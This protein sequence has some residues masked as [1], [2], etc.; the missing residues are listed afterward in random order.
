MKKIFNTLLIIVL[1][2]P[3]SV[4]AQQ[5]P[6]SGFESFESD[7]LNGTGYRPVGWNA[8]NVKRTVVGITATGDL[9]HEYASGRN[10]KCVRI[11]NEAVGAAGIK[12]NAPA[13][14]SLGKPWNF[15]SGV[16]T[17]SATAGTDGGVAF[18]YRPDSLSVWVRRTYSS[19]ED[20]NIV[21]YLWKG[22]SRGDSYR[23]KDGGCSGT[24]HY[25][26]ESDIR[27]AYDGNDCGTAVVATQIGEGS[28]RSNA[29]ITSWT[30]VKVPIRY[31]TND[32]PEKMNVILSAGN[33]P[34]KRQSTGVYVGSTLFCD[35]IKFIYSSRADQILLNNRPMNGFDRDKLKYSVEL[36]DAAT[37]IPEIT[38]KRSGRNLAPSE[39]TIV[40]GGVGGTT[41]ITIRAED[42]KSSTTYSI[43]F[44]TKLS[45]NPRPDMISVGGVDIPNFIP[46]LYEYDVE[47]PFGTTKCPEI[48]VDI[49]EGGQT[50]TVTKPSSL[51]GTAVVNVV[52][53][54]VAYSQEY[55]INM[56]VGALTDNTLTGI[57]VDGEM[58]DNFLPTTNNYRLDLPLGTTSTPEITYTTA[59]P[60]DHNVVVED[61]GI[62]G[63]V[64]ISVTPKGTSLTRVYRITFRITESSNAKLSALLVDGD[65]IDGFSADVLSYNY[66]LPL[67]TSALPSVTWV[68]GDDYQNVELQLG[69]LDGETRIIVTAQSGDVRVYKINFKTVK[70][71]V[72][73]LKNIY[74]DS[75]AID[76]FDASIFEYE[77]KLPIGTT[78]V[79]EVTWEEGDGYQTV[80]LYK[81][82]LSGT[83]RVVVKAQNG[84][85]KTYSI[86]F[87]VMKADNS[88]LKDIL[89]GGVSVPNFHS[90]TLIYNIDLP[91]GTS[92]LPEITYVA[93]DA[94]QVIRKVEGGVDGVT[95]IT[96]KAQ[97]GAMTVYE[98]RFSVYKSSNSHLADIIVDGKTIEGFAADK[99]EYFD[100]LPSGTIDL[101]TIE[102]VKGDSYQ[103]VIAA[104]EG[105][106][107]KSTITVTAEDGTQSVYVIHF[108]VEKSVSA[109]LK[110]IFVD[111][112]K[113]PNFS[114]DVMSY[115]MT[116]EE[117]ATECP[118]VTVDKDGSQSVTITKPMFEGTVKIE[119]QPEVGSKNV[120]TI[121]FKKKES[122]DVHLADITLGGFSIPNYVPTES[123]Y[124]LTVPRGTAVVPVV[125]YTRNDKRQSVY[126]EKGG[127]NE[128]TTIHV[129][130]E[131]GETFAYRLLIREEENAESTL[132]D[133]KIGGVSLAGFRADSLDYEYELPLTQVEIPSVE[134]VKSDEGQSIMYV[135]PQG[136]GVATI[137]VIA[138]DKS[139]TTMYT[140]N[141]IRNAETDKYLRAIYVDGVDVIGSAIGNVINVDVKSGHVP[142]V[143]YKTINS[144]QRVFVADAGVKGAKILVVAGDGTDYT[145]ELVYNELPSDVSDLVD[146]RLHVGGVDVT[147]D[148]FSSDKL[149][150]DYVLPLGTTILP[151][152]NVSAAGKGCEIDVVYGG[153]NGATTIDVMAED[154]VSSKQYVI[155]FSTAKSNVSTV[156]AIYL[157]G[158][159]IDGF[160][161]DVTDYTHILPYGATMNPVVTWD[162]PYDVNG[163]YVKNQSFEL[164]E[165]ADTT[166]LRV[167]SESG[168][169]MEYRIEFQ[170]T[171]SDKANEL[172]M[173]T[174][175]GKPVTGFTKSGMNYS[176]VLPYGT[177][178]LPEI[179]YTK[180]YD[181]QT[182]IVQ[183]TS[184]TEDAT[185][186]VMSNKPGVADVTYTISLSVS[187][188]HPLAITSLK[189]N[190]AEVANFDPM[191]TKYVVPVTAKPTITY[192]LADGVD[193]T[194]LLDNHKVL[195]FETF[196][197]ASAETMVYEIYYY[198][199]NDVIPNGD[200]SDWSAKTKYNNK[201]KP[202]GWMV[203]ADCD[204]AYTYY[205]VVKYDTYT[206][207]TE[208]ANSSNMLHLRAYTSKFSI[209]G[210]VPSMVSLAGMKLNLD[211]A[212]KS[213]SSVSG[214]VTFRNTP[215]KMNLRYK[216][217]SKGD[218]VDGLSFTYR[219]SGDGTNYQQKRHTDNTF[220]N[221]WKNMS[222]DLA[223]S[224]TYPTHINIILN[225]THSENAKD[226]KIPATGSRGMIQKSDVYVDDLMFEYN[227]YLSSIKVADKTITMSNKAITT[228]N[229]TVDANLI[230]VPAVSVVGEVAD[231]DH[232]VVMSDEVN[233][234]RTATIKV[235][236][237]DGKERVY[238]VKIT[239][240]KSVNNG[241][242]NILVDGAALSGF[243][244]LTKEY[245]V[246]LPNGTRTLPDV[247]VVGYAHQTIVITN[248]GA[249]SKVNVTAEDGTQ[250]E[251]VINYVESKD[252]VTALADVSVEGHDISYVSTTYDYNVNIANDA[253]V[254]RVSYV[255]TNNGQ[256]VNMT[257]D[258]DTMNINVVAQNGTDAADYKVVFVRDEIASTA[259][260]VELKLNDVVLAGFADTVY[261]YNVADVPANSNWTFT[262]GSVADVVVQTI[263]EDAVQFAVQGVGVANVYTVNISSTPSSS[264]DLGAIRHNGSD[265]AI[266]A[267][268]IKDYALDYVKTDTMHL[269]AITSDGGQLLDVKKLGDWNKRMDTVIYVVQAENATID[270]TTIVFNYTQNS[271]TELANIILANDTISLD[272]A[273]YTSDRLFDPSE[274]VYNITLKADSPK[275]VS[276][277]M[278]TISAISAE[279]GQQITVENNGVDATSYITVRAEDGS[280]RMYEIR[281]VEE[282]SENAYL[283]NIIVDAADLTGFAPTTFEYTLGSVVNVPNVIATKGDNFQTVMQTQVADSTVITVVSESKKDTSVYVIRHKVARSSEAALV[284]IMVNGMSVD[285]FHRDTLEYNVSLPLGSS[286]KADVTTVAGDD[287]Q[288]V[289][290][291]TAQVDDYQLT[292]TI[293]VTAEDGVTQ[294]V[295][296]LNFT[297]EKSVNNKLMSILLNGKVIG[298][299]SSEIISSHAFS[300][301]VN[302]YKLQLPVGT[303]AM[304]IVTWTAGDVYQ[305]IVKQDVSADSV[306]VVVDPQTSGL[307]NVYTLK[308]EVLKSNN[309][310]LNSIEIDGEQISVDA[311]GY[312]TNKD[313]NSNVYEYKIT[314]PVGSTQVP[315]VTC[316]VGDMWQ[317]VSVTQA[318]SVNDTAAIEVVAG[319]GVTRNTYKVIF[320]RKLSQN[321]ELNMISLDNMPLAGFEKD[322]FVYNHELPIGVDSLP[323]VTWE[324]GDEYQTVVTNVEKVQGSSTQYLITVTAEDTR[325]KN[326][327]MIIFTQ[328]KSDNAQLDSIYV[329][330]ENLNGFDASIYS[331]TYEV[332]YGTVVLPSV[333]PFKGEESQFIQ[334]YPAATIDDTTRIIVT[335]EDGVTTNTYEVAYREVPSD[336]AY[337]KYITIGGE[338]M[339]VNARGFEVDRSFAYSQFYYNIVLPYGTSR[340]PEIMYQGQVDDYDTMYIDLGGMEGLSKITVV[341]QDESATN[342]YNLMFT[343]AKSDEAYLSGITIGGELISDF[344]SLNYEYELHYPIGTSYDSL[345]GDGDF[346]FVKSHEG[347]TVTIESS[348]Q[349]DFHKQTVFT[350]I[351]ENGK[352]VRVYVVDM[353]IAMNDDS[354]LSDIIVNGA[355]IISFSPTQ[356]E[357]TYY[358]LPGA[359]VPEVV[360]VKGDESQEVVVVAGVVGEF[361]RIFVTAEDGSESEY[362]IKFVYTTE[363]PGDAPTYDDVAWVPM[364][365]GA[366][367]ASSLR[368][369]VVVRIVDVSG[370]T[371]RIEKVDVIDPN[372]KITEPHE[373]GTILQFDP[374]TQLYIYVFVCDGEVVSSGKFI[375]T[376]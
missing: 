168:D 61:N 193:K 357:Y 261:N 84:D 179:A 195:K 307:T 120:Y 246:A 291:Q 258:N 317:V 215:E 218:P 330:G 262:A 234:E 371:I 178:E 130:A 355:S 340:A 344:D 153:V 65:T 150:Y 354:L 58:I 316:Q 342:E 270:T 159:L 145:Y 370:Q 323:E 60:D 366:F 186:K 283:K 221:T 239:R 124:V 117:S 14:I 13:W 162:V 72:S 23:N 276:P 82:N 66:E 224:V 140:V 87:S 172:V 201:A 204:D 361:T 332:P 16:N 155:N 369:N 180:S 303:V 197:L 184:V 126:V 259:K 154:G 30:E 362:L 45:T 177:T 226:L 230:G 296:V 311:A 3:L 152:I 211:K 101:P 22:T 294:R 54:D 267:P 118:D 343:V 345:P 80:T 189:V 271:N 245:T 37:N 78:N 142:N 208:V 327:Y 40:D 321:N 306:C 260:L 192:T 322:K 351:A 254:P 346:A 368:Q 88:T 235:K 86:R 181:E 129:R 143:T 352:T 293:T 34:N 121:E 275:L 160:D 297:L 73:T 319:D 26:E 166:I 256:E 264:V 318:A 335:A 69:G 353:Y 263:G 11:H 250:S 44:V 320:S 374:K 198:Y 92:S 257:L 106:N 70:S 48:G 253:V 49:A 128:I 176:V 280:E 19:K 359:L 242:K 183:S 108:T 133:I 247:Q 76:G 24:T 77:V 199:K 12:E 300:P 206:T 169:T 249:Q 341:S 356:F 31:L 127:V 62:D 85:V 29:Q 272:N 217:V 68:K 231:Q 251:Y 191:K 222:M 286:I 89:V 202:K 18:R 214:G 358:L 328:A 308:F 131:S 116:L 2:F 146:I 212:G 309:A 182:V 63:G 295:Y 71:S 367:K 125:G 274:L 301:E 35:D 312:E 96:V 51:P 209:Q 292:K 279:E 90:D 139:D 158:T 36:G 337:L 171:L 333:E 39:Y 114:S 17:G 175:G 6:N 232:E 290:M 157:D 137:K 149:V 156:A 238:T 336:N 326:T 136:K 339:T 203:P 174:V 83:T 244:S 241:L 27:L 210:G 144:A 200:F 173:I 227:N 141:F 138:E 165:N 105:V 278:P 269:R 194:V 164:I 216:P 42:G 33:Y 91:R 10:G 8:A 55:N 79:P 97:S 134:A 32:V 67:G 277:E 299:A 282:K 315:N 273:L 265:L 363:N 28:W 364:G 237:E 268:A 132:A 229:V 190:G 372:E 151:N 205:L 213:T 112:K 350:V 325:Y 135:M 20:A 188:V 75:V 52:A 266:F 331:Y 334:I 167:V 324:N 38:L 347:Q 163:E 314:L 95:R 233:G 161:K 225:G 109:L 123:D 373:S 102:A 298:D 170:A 236:G 81:S 243:S 148:G 104:N 313:F 93:N 100:T 53:P 287:G 207:G 15:L 41:T 348:K 289:D 64:K 310:Q 187:Q 110:M 25:D 57:Y 288:N 360:G 119:V 113:L 122:S 220:N 7:K 111:G 248:S 4:V 115:S 252:N 219:V 376:Q 375:V 338:M 305:T 94:T 223:T 50:Y 255:K 103:N 302:D 21:V 196:S 281:V 147:I 46:Y 56:T 43:D 285:G 1:L 59:Y 47:L 98:L 329:G 5:L 304:P 185:L 349:T 240:P 365:G 107:G 74:L 99:Y 9:V 284:D 228:Y